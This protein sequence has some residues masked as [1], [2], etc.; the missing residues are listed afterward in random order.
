M[1]RRTLR[2]RTVR[3]L[4]A[5]AIGGSA[6]QLSGCDPSVRSTLLSGLAATTNSL[7]DAL[8]AAWFLSF[9]DGD[10]SG[11]SSLTTN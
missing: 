3:F 8:I 1:G 9:D 10:S 6:F 11:G 5:L 4:T 2:S 7:A